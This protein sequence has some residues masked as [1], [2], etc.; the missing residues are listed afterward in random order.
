M[1]AKR[2]K[3][4]KIKLVMIALMIFI[5]LIFIVHTYKKNQPTYIET[6]TTIYV[7][8]GDTLWKIAEEYARPNQDIRD[9]IYKVKELNNMQTSSLQEGQELQIIIYE[10]IK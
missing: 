1:K 10:E 2:Y 5:S 4:D 9:Y 3:K 6:Y 8:R 7:S